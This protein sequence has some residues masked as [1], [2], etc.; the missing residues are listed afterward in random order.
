MDAYTNRTFASNGNIA[1][2]FVYGTCL[3]VRVAPNWIYKI[4]NHRK[5]ST[6]SSV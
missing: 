1:I 6:P 4:E 2:N 3:S 5:I